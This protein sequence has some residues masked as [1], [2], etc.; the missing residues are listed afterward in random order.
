MG[1]VILTADHFNLALFTRP[2]SGV[3]EVVPL[4]LIYFIPGLLGGWCAVAAVAKITTQV[5]KSGVVIEDHRRDAWVGPS[6]DLRGLQSEPWLV[7][8][9]FN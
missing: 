1:V 8:P 4:M 7:G 3:R 6:S 5:T 9:D 2:W